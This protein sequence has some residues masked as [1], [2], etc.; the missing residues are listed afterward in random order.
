MIIAHYQRRKKK[1][2]SPLTSGWYCYYKPHP[3]LDQMSDTISQ[4]T[5]HRLLDQMSDT[6][7]QWT[8]HRLPTAYSVRKFAI[9]ANILYH[10]MLSSIYL[11]TPI[12]TARDLYHI[13]SVPE[14]VQSSLCL[15]RNKEITFLWT[16]KFKMSPN[17]NST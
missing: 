10:C 11:Q 17:L 14:D 16:K 13:Y 8:N 7:F 3:A 9:K 12:P 15:V 2:K 5:N 6:I 1:T 4:W